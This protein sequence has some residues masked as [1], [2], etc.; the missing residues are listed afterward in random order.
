M[1][2]S[3]MAENENNKRVKLPLA[4]NEVTKN[5]SEK[6]IMNNKNKVWRKRF[7]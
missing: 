2:L 5:R 7:H 1:R 4:N 6:L 3:E